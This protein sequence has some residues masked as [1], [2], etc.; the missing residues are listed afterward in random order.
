MQYWSVV[1]SLLS[2]AFSILLSH[3]LEQDS[4]ENSDPYSPLI[5]CIYLPDEFIICDSLEKPKND[6]GTDQGIGCSAKDFGYQKYDEVKK[7]SVYCHV[8]DESIE[9]AGNRTFKKSGIPC[10]KYSGYC[11]ISTLL[12]SVFL[13]CLGVDRFCLGH[14]GVGVAK[15]LTLGGL[16]VWWFIDIILLLTGD[17][18]PVD[19]SN[20]CEY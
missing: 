12:Y 19:K 14:T 4:Q 17:L 15:F 18:I 1:F 20:W 6:S 9:C 7:T 8:L 16:G 3:S 11:F 2:L 13:G 10:I 5:P